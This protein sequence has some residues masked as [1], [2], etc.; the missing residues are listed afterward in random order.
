MNDASFDY[1]PFINP[2]HSV[3]PRVQGNLSKQDQSIALIASLILVG[4][5]TLFIPHLIYVIW[6]ILKNSDPAVSKIHGFAQGLLNSSF[7]TD[8]SINAQNSPQIAAPAA[9]FPDDQPATLNEIYGNKTANLAI[10]QE[11]FKNESDV[12]VPYFEGISHATILAFIKKNFVLFDELWTSYVDQVQRTGSVSST[13][14][15]LIQEGILEAFQSSTDFPDGSLLSGFLLK[16]KYL[17]VR[18]T[19]REDGLQANP[20]GNVSIPN[21]PLVRASISAAIGQV[22]ASYFSVKSLQQRI[23]TGDDITTPPFVPVLLQVMFAE[24]KKGIIPTS[25]VLF[26]RECE[27]NTPGITQICASFGHAEAVVTGATPCDTFYAQG[28]YIHSVIKDKPTRKVPGEDGQLKEA[29]NPR[30]VRLLACLTDPQ[31]LRLS[32][33]GSRIEKHYQEPMDIEWS[34]C[35]GKIILFQARPIPKKPSSSPNYIDPDKMHEMKGFQKVIT[36]GAAGG[37]VLALTARNTLVA[38]TAPEALEL[39][40]ERT[41]D[42]PEAILIGTATAANSHE[43]SFF[44]SLGIPIIQLSKATFEQSSHLLE[45]SDLLV[46]TQ[47]SILAVLPKGAS[48]E[49]FIKN[50]LQRFLAPHMESSL[51]NRLSHQEATDF[52]AT[53]KLLASQYTLISD[54]ITPHNL[55]NNLEKAVSIEEKAAI[56]NHLVRILQSKIL[57]G[58][59]SKEKALLLGKILYNCKH[60]FEVSCDIASPENEK[61]FAIHWLRSSITDI[62]ASEAVSASTLISLLGEKKEYSILK[63]PKSPLTQC[64]YLDIFTRS[65]KFIL[66]PSTRLNWTCFITQL[67]SKELEL[68]AKIFVILGPSLIPTFLNSSF[69]QSFKSFMSDREESASACLKNL[70]TPF[71]DT[72]TVEY[73][74]IANKTKAHARTFSSLVNNFGKIADFDLLLKKMDEEFIPA[75]HKNLEA[76]VTSSGLATAMLVDAFTVSISVFDNCI[77]GLTASPEYTSLPS[78]KISCFRKLLERYTNLTILSMDTRLL[79]HDPALQEQGEVLREFFPIILKELSQPDDENPKLL[80]PSKSFSVSS[81]SLGSGVGSPARAPPRSLEDLFTTLHQ[82]LITAAS[83]INSRSGLKESELPI[84]IQEFCEQLRMLNL[85]NDAGKP[86]LQSIT[87]NYPHLMI[88]F[89][90]PLNYHSSQFMIDVQLSPT[91]ELS[92]ICLEGRFYVSLGGSGAFARAERLR[93]YALKTYFQYQMQPDPKIGIPQSHR[94]EAIVRWQ[95]ESGAGAK[96]TFSRGLEHL[97]KMIN[98]LQKQIPL[99]DYRYGDFTDII[100]AHPSIVRDIIVFR[101][102]PPSNVQ[103]STAFFKALVNPISHYHLNLFIDC[104]YSFKSSIDPANSNLQLLLDRVIDNDFWT[105]ADYETKTRTIST[106]NRFNPMFP[107]NYQDQGDRAFFKA[108]PPY[109]S[110]RLE[111][112]RDRWLSIKP[113]IE[114]LGKNNCAYTMISETERQFVEL[115]PL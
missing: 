46:D 91:G 75:I 45:G 67:K 41:I 110:K 29:L 106:L 81:A 103:E 1:T 24:E 86:T 54:K 93:V 6:K 53:L 26:T 84:Q 47:E 77:K 83:S 88:C 107:P 57:E 102:D 90:A 42:S 65:T 33:I 98:F 21:I 92:S 50:G 68:L 40:L 94:D 100:E 108:L 97:Q 11:L 79:S 18:S 78:L 38:L 87:Y 111:T 2:H 58:V 48:K 39:F 89:N 55:V 56:L 25:G 96:E 71:K 31:I 109:D 85:E 36:L 10:L 5:F 27:L 101:G 73:L 15:N 44:S 23:L 69:P 59:S 60:Y 99:F 22:I 20:G 30:S 62:P 115:P 51:S 66:S 112:L 43:A 74:E 13:S 95:I 32:E 16:G 49:A 12:I 82:S 114:A 104:V 70:L 9:L 113:R 76:L 17:M 37:R 28:Q 4:I 64:E 63:T 34:Y 61:K 80:L 52:L 8:K 7:P 19:G 72:Q 105:S 14:L 35:D 3:S